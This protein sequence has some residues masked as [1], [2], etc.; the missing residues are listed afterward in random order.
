[1]PA[2]N[3]RILYAED[4]ADTREMVTALFEFVGYQITT[5]ATVAESVHSARS[6]HFD[7]YIIDNYYTDGSGAELIRQLRA[8]DTRTP[9][10]VYSGSSTE[11]DLEEALNSGAQRYLV[12]PTEMEILNRTISELLDDYRQL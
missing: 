10:I 11:E 6:G 8:F 5:A 2:R 7:L 4:D 12:K 1:M 9:I 3:W